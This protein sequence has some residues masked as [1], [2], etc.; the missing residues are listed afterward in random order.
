MCLLERCKAAHPPTHPPSHPL[1]SAD[2]LAQ[3]GVGA[4]HQGVVWVQEAG[5]HV[6]RELIIVLPG[7]PLVQ[8]L[9]QALLLQQALQP[10]LLVGSDLPSEGDGLGGHGRGQEGDEQGSLHP[11]VWV[12]GQDG[13]WC[14]SSATQG[15]CIEWDWWLPPPTRCVGPWPCMAQPQAAQASLSGHHSQ[16]VQPPPAGTSRQAIS[17][18]PPGSTWGGGSS[19]SW[20]WW[21]ACP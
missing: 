4:T 1:T 11:R 16:P 14:E 5:D 9:W 10:T 18:H 7:S 6:V 17:P 21:W 20:S 12:G 15:M 8:H 13:Q 3:D 19:R 2:A